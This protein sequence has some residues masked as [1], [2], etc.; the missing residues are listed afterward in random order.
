MRTPELSTTNVY[1]ST[2]EVS[3]IV[4]LLGHSAG[5]CP[6]EHLMRRLGGVAVSDAAL[7]RCDATIRVVG[8]GS[9]RRSW[10][11]GAGCHT[12]IDNHSRWCSIPCTP[13]TRR[14]CP[15]RRRR[16]SQGSA[17]DCHR[18][19]KTSVA[20]AVIAESLRGDGGVRDFGCCPVKDGRT[21]KADPFQSPR[22]AAAC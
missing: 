4:S 20:L 5:G 19:K 15:V 10:R 22:T 1:R 12:L 13:C 21:C 9:W 11:Y 8:I 18:P 6:G 16:N 17:R 2:S 7:A 14:V 3:E